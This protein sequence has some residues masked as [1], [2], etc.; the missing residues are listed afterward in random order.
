M[1]PVFL[2]EGSDAIARWAASRGL[3]Y[4]G[5]PDQAWF[6]AWEPFD[7][8]VAA[9]WYLNACVWHA[10][11]GSITLCE[12]WMEDGPGEPID[13]T[14]LAFVS[15][16]GLRWRAAAR[17]G[18]HFLTRVT[19]IDRPP[20]PKVEL[21]EA[22][23]DEHVVTHAASVSEALHALPASLRALLQAWGF[24]GHLE[25][26]PGGCVVHYAGLGPTPASYEDLTRIAPELVTA[27]LG[28][29]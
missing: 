26:R 25:M 1:D 23:W 20:P 9:S 12:P 7:T 29:R 24:R 4:Q 19:Y 3:L 11:V 13:R 18:E 22:V 15:H 28:Q 16:R 10:P 21:G 6:Q 2:P 27:A 5:R 14:V 17:V 8:M